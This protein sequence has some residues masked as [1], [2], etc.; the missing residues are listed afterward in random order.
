MSVI[1]DLDQQ[2][3]Q[4]YQIGNSPRYYIET[5]LQD[6]MIYRSLIRETNSSLVITAPPSV[7]SPC[8]RRP[9]YPRL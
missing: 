3:H 6:E 7:G 8:P 5:P 4:Y 2:G 1:I 9:P